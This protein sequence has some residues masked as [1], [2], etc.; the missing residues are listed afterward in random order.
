[1]GQR[2][3]QLWRRPQSLPQLKR[4]WWHRFSASTFPQWHLAVTCAQVGCSDMEKRRTNSVHDAAVGYSKVPSGLLRSPCATNEV[5]AGV[6][7]ALPLPGVL[8]CKQATAEW[9][10]V[11]HSIHTRCDCLPC[12]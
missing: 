4:D 2:C 7:L 6:K 5:H 12:G 1:M 8:P 9:V 10:H 11:E 3:P